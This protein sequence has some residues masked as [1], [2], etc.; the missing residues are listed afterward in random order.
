VPYVRLFCVEDTVSQSITFQVVDHMPCKC[1]GTKW[2]M[3]IE[4]AGGRGI[5][6]EPSNSRDHDLRTFECPRCEQME[7]LVVRFK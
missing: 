4:P 1:G 7:S 6:T 3:L 2:L 5:G